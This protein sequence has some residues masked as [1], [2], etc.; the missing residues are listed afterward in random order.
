MLCGT[1]GNDIQSYSDRAQVQTC[2]LANLADLDTSKPAVQNLLGTY[3][4]DLLNMGVK[5]YRIDAAKHIAAQDLAAILNGLTRPGGG[6]PYIFQEVIDQGGEPVK[7]FEY[8]PNGDVT[9]FKVSIDLGYIFNAGSLTSLQNFAAGYLP[10]RFAVVFTDNHDNQRGHGAGGAY[11]LDHRDGFDLYNLGNIFLLAYPYGHPSVMSSFYWSNNPS[12]NAGDSKGPPSTTSPFTSGSGAETSPVYSTTQ[13]TG[14]IPANCSDTFADGKW[15]CE[16]RRTA[17]ANMVGFRQ[18][19]VGEAVTDWVN[20]SANHIAF[21]RGT[22]GYVTINRAAANNTR[23]YTTTMATGY[24]CNVT[25]YD[26]NAVTGHCVQP[27]TNTPAP[28]SALIKVEPDGRILNQS[29][30]AM[31]AFAIHVDAK[32]GPSSNGGK[33]CAAMTARCAMD[34]QRC[35][36]SQRR[37]YAC[38][39]CLGR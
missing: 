31:T 35:M 30:S 26:F 3:L 22:K 36:G 39:L 24:Y 37:G 2:E 28:A 1:T 5:G 6:S 15:V 12:S 25:Q 7:S 17:I 23:T 18:A 38:R 32:L 19:T 33:N 13:T 11:I 9:E 21:G 16:H 4:Q 29:V 20:V 27:G 8:T 34:R 14:D 10:S